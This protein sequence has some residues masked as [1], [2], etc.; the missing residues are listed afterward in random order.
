MG[1]R[2]APSR[3][4]QAGR[5]LRY[6]PTG[7]FPFLL[8][9]LLLCIQL[10]GGQKKKEVK[11]TPSTPETGAG[12]GGSGR[13]LL[14]GSRTALLGSRCVRRGRWRPRGGIRAGGRLLDESFGPPSLGCGVN[15]LLSQK[16]RKHPPG[17]APQRLTSFR[18]GAL[19]TLSSRQTFG[20]SSH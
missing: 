8:L 6:L 5:R 12:W 15:R 19:L 16:I 1:A 4:R 13:A 11:P 7:S 14:L 20:T 2:G 9:L 10:G 18:A 3:R 17:S